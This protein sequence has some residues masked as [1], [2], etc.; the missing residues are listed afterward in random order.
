[1]D[2]N[3]IGFVEL[4]RMKVDEA[5]TSPVFQE[6]VVELAQGE[7][8]KD[9]LT[10]KTC[11][12]IVVSFRLTES[13]SLLGPKV[14]ESMYKLRRMVKDTRSPL[15]R[16]SETQDTDACSKLDH[17]IQ[18]DIKV[19]AMNV[20]ETAA[21]KNGVHN[22]GVMTL[23]RFFRCF[24]M[25]YGELTDDEFSAKMLRFKA[26]AAGIVQA[27]KDALALEEARRTM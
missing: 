16:K 27:R 11:E 6:K 18:P 10:P 22:D 8:L 17:Q 25:L 26:A 7:D 23:M 14:P 5:S 19:W 4:K 2:A 9:E 1:M 3:T 13:P 24:T 12:R 21:F 15:Y 20:A